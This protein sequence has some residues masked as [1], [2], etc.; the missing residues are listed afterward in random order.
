MQPA[1]ADDGAS[2]S[3]NLKK[4][5]PIGAIVLVAA[6]VVGLIVVTGAEDDDEA[7]ATD[8][9]A[10]PTAPGHRT[11]STG[12]DRPDGPTREPDTTDRSPTPPSPTAPSRWGTSRSR[13]RSA[14]P[15]SRA[16]R[17]TGTSGATRRPATSRPVVL[18][19]RV[20]RAVR[21]RQRRRDDARGHRRHDQGRAV[22][23]ARQRPDHQLPVRR[24]GG[25]PTPT[26]SPSR[27]RATCCGMFEDFYEFYGRTIELEVY[28]SSGLANDEVTARADAV[29]IAEDSSRSRAR[30]PG[31]DE[32]VRRRAR[33]ARRDVHRV[34][35]GAAA[36]VV[37]RSRPVRVR[38]GD[39]RGAEPGPRP[40]VHR[41]A[42]G[43]QER[44]VRRRRGVPGAAA[45]V[46]ARVHLVEPGVAGDRRDL[47]ER[48][49][50]G[51][52]ERRRALPYTLDPASIQSQASQIIAKLKS[53]G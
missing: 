25:R 32:R 35:A 34:H 41:Q 14:R 6:A 16:S 22:L 8:T 42:A 39:R 26:R 36:V 49:D 30:R 1:H 48:V 33:G 43:R 17:S 9:T 37:R 5:G 53:S 47:R 50:R 21:G 3:N 15:R 19:P 45:R 23:R 18:R 27:R 7:T 13:C 52:G 11:G 51:R 28:V 10:R 44:R 40:R 24:R 4:W 2:S 38:P 20:L 12:H 46:R 31:V 29:R